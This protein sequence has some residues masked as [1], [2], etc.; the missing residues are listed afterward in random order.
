MKM[1]I[2]TRRDSLISAYQNWIKRPRLPALSNKP[3]MRAMID[4]S[5]QGVSAVGY[6]A[7]VAGS[8]FCGFRFGLRHLFWFVTAAS[9]LLAVLAGFPGGGYGPL[10]ILMG[11]SVISLHLISTAVGSH[12]RAEADREA[13]V[14]RSSSAFS[15]AA[16]ELAG[17]SLPEVA[18][19]SPLH[20]RGR[21]MGRLPLWVAFGVVIGGASGAAL[22][23]L[24]IGDRTTVVGV[25]VGAIST[26]VVGGWFAFLG[27][28]F[29]AILRQGWQDAVS[30]PK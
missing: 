14:S 2:K 4:E 26:A 16:D 3:I 25:A 15:S 17:G 28:S 18:C 7:A 9:I 6:H 21:P 23:E 24:A 27:G 1:K 30:E 5:K 29:W 19:Q 11:L 13:A 12:L 20:T 8:L 10:A 22:L